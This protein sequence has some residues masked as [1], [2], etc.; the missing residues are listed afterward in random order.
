MKLKRY[1]NAANY[2]VLPEVQPDVEIFLQHSLK[3]ALKESDFYQVLQNIPGMDMIPVE[4]SEQLA[5]YIAEAAYEILA[6]SYADTQGRL[7]FENL[8]TNFRVA[9][10]KELQN[11]K[12]QQELQP[13]LSD[14]LEELKLNYI[15]RTKEE[16]PEATLDEAMKISEEG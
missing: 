11:K 16:N 14:L 1:C 12:L 9:L 10:R 8:T 2:K 4:L 13:L 6:S 15:Q 3:G 5:D 7:L